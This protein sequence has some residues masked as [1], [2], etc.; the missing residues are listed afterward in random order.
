[1]NGRERI[2]GEKS[3]TKVRQLLIEMQMIVALKQK[4]Y[5][6]VESRSRERSGDIRK[7][8]LLK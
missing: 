4:L 2:V 5:G 6:R 8:R 1:V 3:H 7:R